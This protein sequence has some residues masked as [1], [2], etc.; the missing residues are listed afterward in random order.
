MGTTAEPLLLTA[1]Q[2][3]PDAVGGALSAMAPYLKA[4]TVFGGP[5]AVSPTVESEIAARVHGRLQ[6]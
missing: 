3:L 6:Q 5:M 1:P 2:T 4:V